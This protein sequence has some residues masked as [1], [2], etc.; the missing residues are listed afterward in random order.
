MLEPGGQLGFEEG[1][2]VQ[3]TWSVPQDLACPGRA[4]GRRRR[5]PEP[6]STPSSPRSTPAV[7]SPTTG[8]ATSPS[9]WTPWEYDYFGAPAKAQATVRPDCRR[10]LR[11]RTGRRAGQRRSRRP[12]LVV[13]VGGH[14][15]VPGDPGHRRPG[16]RQPPVPRGR[17]DPARRQAA[18]LDAPGASASTPYIH[19]SWSAGSALAARSGVHRR[20][21]VRSAVRRPG[22]GPGPGCR[23]DHPDRRASS[24]SG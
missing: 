24:P 10:P 19:S 5:R 22:R 18:V 6:S 20:P 14:G 15:D 7:T 21:V 9:L 2:A 13:R 23:L 4:D 8:P 12:L 1:N 16:P 3:Y 11:R 17:P